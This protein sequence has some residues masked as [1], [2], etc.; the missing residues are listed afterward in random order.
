MGA[1]GVDA[2]HHFRG[3]LWVG[4][5]RCQHFEFRK[6]SDDDILKRLK[7]IV[8]KEGKIID[9]SYLMILLIMPRAAYV[10]RKVCWV[11]FYL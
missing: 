11:K 2:D 5:S 3:N 10:I 9:D 4:I 6:V 8:K 7:T 1:H